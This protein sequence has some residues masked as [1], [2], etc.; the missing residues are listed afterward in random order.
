M[1]PLDDQ[2]L[3]FLVELDSLPPG[4]RDGNRKPLLE[5]V[6]AV[7]DL[8]QEEVEQRPQLVEVVLQ[9]GAG[10]E[11]PML[12]VILPHHNFGEP[13]LLVFHTMPLVHDN[14]LP[15][16]LPQ[17]VTVAHDEIVGGETHIPPAG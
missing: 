17:D 4:A 16:V 14:I 1:Q 8:G 5:V 9:G 15:M 11:Q 10:Q 3:L 7:K 2:V 13:A 12:E 6:R